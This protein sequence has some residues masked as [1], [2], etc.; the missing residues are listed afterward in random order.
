MSVASCFDKLSMTPL[1][2]QRPCFYRVTL[3]LSKGGATHRR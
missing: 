3:S 1:P 2:T